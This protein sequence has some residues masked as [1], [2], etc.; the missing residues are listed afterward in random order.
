MSQRI[1]DIAG[2]VVLPAVAADVGAHGLDVVV[3]PERLER[4]YV[5]LRPDGAAVLRPGLLGRL[6]GDEAGELDR[7]VVGELLGAGG[8]P[9]ALGDHLPHEP[10]DVGHRQR[11]ACSAFLPVR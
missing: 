2:C 11:G 8:D 10:L 7:A 3:E 9:E 1:V 4:G 6:A 5:V